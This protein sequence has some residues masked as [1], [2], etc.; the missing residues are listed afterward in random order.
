[1][2]PRCHIIDSLYRCLCPQ[3][4]NLLASKSRLRPRHLS[5]PA[6]VRCLSTTRP[7]HQST[8]P[9]PEP[10]GAVPII[11]MVDSQGPSWNKPTNFDR[12]EHPFVRHGRRTPHGIEKVKDL[13]H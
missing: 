10:Q 13:A 7:T 12:K 4:S 8:D 5:T 6:S 1:M 11:R 2:A 9:V 3:F